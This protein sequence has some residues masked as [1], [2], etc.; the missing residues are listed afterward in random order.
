M[1]ATLE[2]HRRL[3]PDYGNW[4]GPGYRPARIGAYGF[5]NYTNWTQFRDGTGLRPADNQVIVG[6]RFQGSF[7][8]AAHVHY[9]GCLFKG[10]SPNDRLTGNNGVDPIY[11]NCTWEG[12]DY[13]GAFLSDYQFAI[14]DFGTGLAPG[15]Q[16]IKCVARDFG[17]AFVVAGDYSAN[18][19]LYQDSLI[20]EACLTNDPSTG[21]PYHTDGIGNEDNGGLV[22]GVNINHCVIASR[23]NTNG[24]AFQ[25]GTYAGI[26]TTNSVG[27]GF[28]YLLAYAAT[29]GTTTDIVHTDNEYW[30]MFRPHQDVNGQGDGGGPCYPQL[31]WAKDAN[32]GTW[33]R[34]KWVSVL[35]AARA[36]QFPWATTFE[37]GNPAYNGMF[38]IPNGTDVTAN[39]FD[40]TNHV[41]SSDYNGL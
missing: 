1:G 18:P 16:V 9:I 14:S 27:A 4:T 36:A 23:G 19:Q 24:W 13:S 30:T 22:K 20:Y 37:W 17:N 33:R 25:N 41:S 21:L 5:T 12:A 8:P 35:D 26:H 29:G 10:S 7:N 31:D 40:E 2:I 28:G 11:E 32:G 34:N 38:W 3:T 39:G 6:E 15:M